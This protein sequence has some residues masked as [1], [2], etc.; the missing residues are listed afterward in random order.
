MP[1]S[2][3]LGNLT[4][5]NTLGHPRPVTRLLY[6]YDFIR[7]L[8]TP[9]FQKAEDKKNVALPLLVRLGSNYNFPYIGKKPG[10]GKV[11]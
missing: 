7:P 3:N 6:L 9:V 11:Q 1:L 4:T 5:W 8:V 10:A 2:R